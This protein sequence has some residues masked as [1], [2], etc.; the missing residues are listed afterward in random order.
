MNI[1]D[2]D[3]LNRFKSGFFVDD[4]STTENQ[5]KTTI[6]K[7]AIDYNNGRSYWSGDQGGDV[8]GSFAIKDFNTFLTN[9]TE[10]EILFQS[11]YTNRN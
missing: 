11:Q 2:S 5:I 9:R 8:T 1:T 6:V 7:N 3:G 10:D 4:F